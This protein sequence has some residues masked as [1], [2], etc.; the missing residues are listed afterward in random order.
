MVNLFFTQA[1]VCATGIANIFT[2]SAFNTNLAINK[3]PYLPFM[4]RSE[5]YKKKVGEFSSE[6]N[7]FMTEDSTIFDALSFFMKQKV[8]RMDEF[9]PVVD[10]IKE[11]KVVGSVRTQNMLDYMRSVLIDI[12]HELMKAKSKNQTFMVVANHIEQYLRKT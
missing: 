11:K 4:F 5:L 3:I 2:M 6:I 9:T 12:Q 1:S 7:S 10:S 8:L